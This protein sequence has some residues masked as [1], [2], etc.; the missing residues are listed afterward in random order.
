MPET[1]WVSF[2][3]IDFGWN[4]KPRSGLTRTLS[5]LSLTLGQLVGWENLGPSLKIR[6]VLRQFKSNQ[7]IY[8]VPHKST[9]KTI[10]YNIFQLTISLYCINIKGIVSSELK[11]RLSSSDLRAF[12]Y[13]Q[14]IDKKTSAERGFSHFS[15]YQCGNL[16]LSPAVVKTCPKVLSASVWLFV[17]FKIL[18]CS[19]FA[20][21]IRKMWLYYLLKSKAFLANVSFKQSYFKYNGDCFFDKWKL[22]NVCLF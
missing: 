17:A 10:W 20:Y 2:L 21:V 3:L 15:I 12:F 19:H 5:G 7:L 4:H 9:H 18:T 16:S 14:L 6:V 8:F 22:T 13:L 1:L 11:W